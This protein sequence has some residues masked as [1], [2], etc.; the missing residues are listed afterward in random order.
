L[1]PASVS[2]QDIGAWLD[3]PLAAWNTPGMPVPSPLI[4]DAQLEPLCASQVRSPET[5]QDQAVAEAGWSLYASYEGGWGVMLVSGTSGMDGM[6]R[7]SGYN[8]FVFVDG[9]F[10]GTISPEPMAARATGAGRVI[11]FHKDVVTA[12]FVRYAPTDPLCCPSRGAVLI[13][14]HIQRGPDGPVLVPSRRFEE[15]P[16]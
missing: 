15:P 16:P 9:E 10:A 1:L 14:E 11:S 8:T 2:A 13:E 5:P 3:R 4:P 12:R 7:P 6:C